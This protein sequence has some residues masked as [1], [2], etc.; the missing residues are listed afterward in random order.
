MPSRKRQ[1][2]PTEPPQ[3]VVTGGA[4]FLGS[5][6][7]DLLLERG[8]HVTVLDNLITGSVENIAHLAGRPGF[9]FVSRT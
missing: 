5:H 4:G 6:L 1:T 2:R 8:H 9:R 3:S 7:A